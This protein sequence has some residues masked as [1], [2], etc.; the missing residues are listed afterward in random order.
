MPKVLDLVGGKYLYNG[1]IADDEVY[2]VKKC[3]NCKAVVLA[4]EDETFIAMTP[5]KQK[6]QRI[7]CPVCYSS[8]VIKEK[9]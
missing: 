1:N 4:K 5:I 7:K 2:F 8:I 9:I 3:N 6:S